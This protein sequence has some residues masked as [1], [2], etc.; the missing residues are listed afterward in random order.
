MAE[1]APD[2]PRVIISTLIK[3]SRLDML[4]YYTLLLLVTDVIMFMMFMEDPLQVSCTIY[5]FFSKI[6]F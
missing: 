4:Q 5:I 3:G 2:T 1:A 6:P